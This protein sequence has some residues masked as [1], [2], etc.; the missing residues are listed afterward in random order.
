ME[1]LEELDDFLD[2]VLDGGS[3]TPT[4]IGTRVVR[5]D[6]PTEHSVSI[7]KDQEASERAKLNKLKERI[8]EMKAARS[9]LTESDS[10]ANLTTSK[11]V[12]S[13]FLPHLTLQGNDT[14]NLVDESLVL[15]APS[16][17][18][19][20]YVSVTQLNSPTIFHV[21]GLELDTPNTNSR[22][23]GTPVERTTPTITLVSTTTEQ[24][25]TVDLH[26]SRVETP[27]SLSIS[28]SPQPISE[29][30]SSSPPRARPRSRSP[31]SP[32]SLPDVRSR[33][34]SRSPVSRYP[35]SAAPRLDSRHGTISYP[36]ESRHRHARSNSRPRDTRRS[37]SRSRFEPHRDAIRS[38]P[39]FS[40][41]RS[42]S[43]SR[44]RDR[45]WRRDFPPRDRALSSNT[46]LNSKKRAR[47][48][49]DHDIGKERSENTQPNTK[50]LSS[51]AKPTKKQRTA[52]PVRYSTFGSLSDPGKVAASTLAVTP[53]RPDIH[54]TPNEPHALKQPQPQIPTQ[55][56]ASVQPTVKASN[57]K[58]PLTKPTATRTSLNRTQATKSTLL[59]ALA[60]P[61]A[62]SLKKSPAM[63]RSPRVAD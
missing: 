15:S 10:H 33:V 48:H 44:S 28:S 11:D 36:P 1:G 23:S 62:I 56:T 4:V 19:G 34:R 18:S 21:H 41:P 13:S 6:S 5:K 31:R 47:E 57:V 38:P 9:Q 63:V 29:R 46:D 7:Q 50:D 26:P 3:G 2:Q 22:L 37:R 59:Q 49:P 12:V 40:R 61:T 35:S 24:V 53:P 20:S 14:P 27:S 8:R 45:S 30:Q 51:A 55:P 16:H 43:R 54:N 52:S 58:L 32:R 17:R 39:R 42:R 25:P 60:L